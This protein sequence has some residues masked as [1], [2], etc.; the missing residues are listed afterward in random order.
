M[1]SCNA[2]TCLFIGAGLVSVSNREES[3]GRGERGD[4]KNLGLEKSRHLQTWFGASV[5]IFHSNRILDIVCLACREHCE[6]LGPCYQSMKLRDVKMILW[7]WLR[8]S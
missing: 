5:K 7:K 1:T 4:E 6:P 3:T 8:G 2:R